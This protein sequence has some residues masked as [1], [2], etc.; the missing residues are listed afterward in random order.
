MQ[1]D[2]GKSCLCLTSSNE[3]AP[4]VACIRSLFGHNGQRLSVPSNLKRQPSQPRRVRVSSLGS[5]AKHPETVVWHRPSRRRALRRGK[6]SV[7]IDVTLVQGKG[8][9]GALINASR[10]PLFNPA[11]LAVDEA[12]NPSFSITLRSMDRRGGR[13]VIIGRE[14]E[15][16][17]DTFR[18]GIE[19]CYLLFVFRM[20]QLNYNCIVEMISWYFYIFPRNLY[21]KHFDSSCNYVWCIICRLLHKFNFS[22]LDTS[23]RNS[24]WKLFAPLY[25]SVET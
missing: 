8:G 5:T 21:Y 7:L 6:V 17:V 4:R 9:G 19:R 25:N 24:L 23:T 12:S 14:R 18:C 1:V 10:S 13:V 3:T 15:S 11:W 20:L 2:D 16:C 22:K